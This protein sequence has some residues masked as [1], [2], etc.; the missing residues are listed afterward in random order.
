VRLSRI[1]RLALAGVLLAALALPTAAGAASRQVPRGWLGVTFTPSIATRHHS[2]FDDELKLMRRNGVETVRVAV[3]WFQLQPKRNRKPDYSSLDALVKAAARQR[4]P[5]APVVLGAPKWA[6]SDAS[7]TM[8]QPKDPAD[9]AAFLTRL[10]ERY[11]SKGS[12]WRS[13]RSIHK[14]PIR[15][16]QVWNEVSNPYYW[17][18]DT[19]TTDYP[20]LLRASYDA[21]KKADPRA[22]VVMAGLNTTGD[23]GKDMLTSWQALDRLYDG[24]DAQNL[25]RPFDAVAS[26]IYTSK[27]S[28]AVRVVRETRKVMDAH[29]DSR[30][31]DITELSWPASQHKLR[32]AK[33]RHRAFFAETDQKGMAKRLGK[34]VREL[35]K[36]RK[37]L[38][39][40]AVQ[41]FQWISPYSGTADAFSYSGLRRAHR[42]I[43]DMPA[44]K[45]FRGVAGR[46]EGRRLKG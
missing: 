11:G 29:G 19:W 34:G 23:A 18:Q 15:A 30:P 16:W 33:G 37:A 43:E 22:E 39:I 4:L 7:S 1:L 45:S 36:Q 24:L 44:L 25:G 12:F 17:S 6:A 46:L 2:T 42:H 28:D 5:V 14:T 26:H 31:I 41:W 20:K 8:P 35:A 40:G 10:V 21:V 13:H 3:Y 32:D 27:V 38:G 9:Y